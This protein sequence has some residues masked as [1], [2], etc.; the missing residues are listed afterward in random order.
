MR[1][2]DRATVRV[3][4][5][6][7]LRSL[8]LGTCVLGAGLPSCAPLPPDGV[9]PGGGLMARSEALSPDKWIFYGPQFQDAMRALGFRYATVILEPPDRIDATVAGC[10]RD[11]D[12]ASAQAT[13]PIDDFRRSIKSCLAFDWAFVRAASSG[14]EGGKL[15]GDPYFTTQAY[16]TRAVT[17]QRAG[18]LAST[19][20][21]LQWDDAAYRFIR[22]TADSWLRS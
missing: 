17:Y 10:Y 12:A 11:V 6:R 3:M 8:V 19:Q 4:D 9:T 21:T 18:G 22:G 16:A 20:D 5:P 2:S 7:L 13:A 1:R 14:E 15:T